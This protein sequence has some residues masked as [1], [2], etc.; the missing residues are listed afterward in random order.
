LPA[1]LD[2]EAHQILHHKGRSL[3]VRA[4]PRIARLFHMLHLDR[5]FPVQVDRPSETQ[6]VH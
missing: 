1:A 3:H 5:I 4:T 2:L 6:T